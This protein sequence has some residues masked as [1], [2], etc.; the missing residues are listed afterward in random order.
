MRFASYVGLPFEEGGRDFSG[1]DCWGLVRLVYQQEAGIDLPK[2]CET[3]R[4]RIKTVV[5]GERQLWRE[6][7]PGDE[8][9]LDLVLLKWRPW[10]IGLVVRRGLMLHMK[11][12]QSSMIEPYTSGRY[13]NLIEGFY[14]HECA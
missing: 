9:P 13:G 14:R 1:C 10:H 6:I 11:Q 4:E 3:S 7:A 5:H 8:R 2:Y 12:G